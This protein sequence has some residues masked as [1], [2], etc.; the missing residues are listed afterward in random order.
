MN[1]NSNLKNKEE[2][3]IPYIY[4]SKAHTAFKVVSTSS[5][6]SEHE[7]AI[8]TGNILHDALARIYTDKD[9]TPSLKFL[10]E[11]GILVKEE[12]HTYE[13]L[14]NQVVSHKLLQPYYAENVKIYNEI[15]LIDTDGRLLRPDRIVIS[16]DKVTIIDYKTG[17]PSESYK[18]QLYE[19]AAIISK[20][21]YFVNNK[22]LVYV[23]GSVKPIFV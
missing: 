20:M 2:V 10:V 6:N 22:I 18:N 7:E 3:I 11:Q 17:R 23:D 21:G 14:L 4:N 8:R 12:Y 19:Y 16:G 9:I 13:Q 1:Q 5:F 15:E